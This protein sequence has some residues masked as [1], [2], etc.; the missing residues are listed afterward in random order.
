M[1]KYEIYWNE[2]LNDYTLEKEIDGVKSIKR[3]P[4][5]FKQDDKTSKFRKEILEKELD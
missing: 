3:K 2:K 5:K 4:M 1:V